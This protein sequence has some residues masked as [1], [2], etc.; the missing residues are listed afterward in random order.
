MNQVLGTLH[1]AITSGFTL[2]YPI[3]EEVETTQL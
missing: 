2:D 1:E 3:Q